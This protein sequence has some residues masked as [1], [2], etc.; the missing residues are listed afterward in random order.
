[1]RM[2]ILGCIN[3]SIILISKVIATWKMK[4]YPH[5]KRSIISINKP[6]QI[7]ILIQKQLLLSLK[8]EEQQRIVQNKNPLLKT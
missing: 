4:A 8:L 1:M 3:Y 7:L 2:M 6:S 5:K